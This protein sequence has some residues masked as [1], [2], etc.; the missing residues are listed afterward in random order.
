MKE[1]S[2]V[3]L[4]VN[5][6]HVATLRQARGTRYPD[7]VKAALDAEEAGADGI[8]L[9][10]REDRRH[11][12]ER[13][14]RLLRDLLQT[15]MNLEV[16]LTPEML[17]FAQEIRPEHVCLV[18]ERREELT[19][20][21]GLDVLGQVQRIRDAIAA[22]P[23]SE[24]SLFIDPDLQQIQAAK[25]SG[26]P[27]IELH[28][29]RYAE[30]ETQEAQAHEL[31]RL[32]R[33]VEFATGLGLVVNAGHGLHYHN[34]QP[35]AALPGINELNIGHAIVA[36]AVFVGFKQAVRDMAELIRCNSVVK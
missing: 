24:V 28:T 26:A 11:I 35:I 3:L 22:L 29:G 9:H 33:A 6:D 31:Q 19:T 4:G 15:R 17:A 10:L 27:V 21:G 32:A 8:T 25:D 14:V 30:A 12:Q 2:R 1:F 5:I 36:Q 23:A 7:P 13:D 18:P 20:E 34:V 16:A